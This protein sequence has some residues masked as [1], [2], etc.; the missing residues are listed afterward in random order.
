MDNKTALSGIV[1]HLQRFSLHDG[2]GIRTTVFL[3]GCNLRC[4]WCHNPES[5]IAAPQISVNFNKCTS[6][7]SCVAVCEK[8]IHQ[9]D[10]EKKHIL[11]HAESCI[12]C[13]KC[14]AACPQMAVELIGEPYT[15][16]QIL[17]EVEKD[18]RY[19]DKTGGGVTFSGGEAAFQY[20][21]L[22]ECLALHKE[23]GIH[24]CLET[25]GILPEARLRE[26]SRYAD[27]F[28]LDFKHSDDKLHQQYTGAS[29]RQVY[30][31]LAILDE[32]QKPVL[33]RCP[34]IPGVNDTQAH[35][36]AI[37]EL[38]NRHA[39]IAE[40][41]LMPYHNIGAGKW[42]GLGMTYTMGEVSVPSGETV[43]LWKEAIKEEDNPSNESTTPSFMSE[44]GKT[45]QTL[46]EEHPDAAIKT[47]AIPD[48]AAICFSDPTSN[49][50]YFLFGTQYLSFDDLK[51]DIKNELKC[52]GFVTTADVLFPQATDNM[53]VS[54][55]FSAIG[56]SDYAYDTETTTLQ[57]WVTFKYHN[58]DV[59]LDT[60]SD[61]FIPVETI[62]SSYPVMLIDSN[63]EHEN[64]ELIENTN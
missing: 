23:A 60:T 12:R 15:A 36:R 14:I 55:F 17:T 7:Q 1:F 46:K 40:A 16:N 52:A 34:I 56:V 62:K 49:Y 64:V 35:F 42:D 43:K 44:I 30:E 38:K 51:D 2:P 54:D 25:N 20:D 32:L 33:L 10:A 58:F 27:M 13:K 29:N 21:F 11:I 24:N 9:V 31:S 41:E 19:Y 53:T 18:R 22:L 5:F 28:L 48:A 61:I 59:Y 45:Y 50:E 4:A 47:N 8:Q 39:N 3:K 37:C 6:C 57:G 63:T 26:I